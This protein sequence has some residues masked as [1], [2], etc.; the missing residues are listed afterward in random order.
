MYGQ[1][2]V[3]VTFPLIEYTVLPSFEVEKIKSYRKEIKR[4]SHEKFYIFLNIYLYNVN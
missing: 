4:F 3:N 1:K 2:W